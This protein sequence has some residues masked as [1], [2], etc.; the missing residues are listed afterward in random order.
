MNLH[1]PAATDRCVITNSPSPGPKMDCLRPPSASVSKRRHSFSDIDEKVGSNKRRTPS[2]QIFTTQNVFDHLQVPNVQLTSEKA[3]SAPAQL[4][5]TN[6]DDRRPEEG[7]MADEGPP[8]GER[9]PDLESPSDS[10]LNTAHYDSPKTLS[11]M[12]H[13]QFTPRTE[14]EFVEVDD[15]RKRNLSESGDV[16]L[17]KPEVEREVSFELNGNEL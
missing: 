17:P 14:A 3:S 5:Q 8:E 6:L 13:P 4:V 1:H 11:G 2:E 10:D 15:I 7:K 16:I 12:S 9:S